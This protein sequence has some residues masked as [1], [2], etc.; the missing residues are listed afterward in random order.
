M[1]AGAAIGAR[2]RLIG[3]HRHAVEAVGDRHHQLL[4]NRIA[5]QVRAAA[6]DEG[7]ILELVRPGADQAVTVDMGGEHDGV[8]VSPS[9]DQRPLIPGDF[10]AALF[11]FALQH[12]EKRM[13]RADDAGAAHQASQEIDERAVARHEVSNSSKSVPRRSWRCDERQRNSADCLAGPARPAST[14]LCEPMQPFEPSLQP[15]TNTR[16]MT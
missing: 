4:G 15:E 12:A 8:R 10:S 16:F 9:R 14:K 2:P 5:E 1:R 11:Q 6:G 7:G 13:L 3:I